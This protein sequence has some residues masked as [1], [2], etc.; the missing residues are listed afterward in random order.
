MSL[1]TE[2]EKRLQQLEHRKMMIPR[3]VDAN[4]NW[5]GK[6]H[7]SLDQLPEL[8]KMIDE[9]KAAIAGIDN[10]REINRQVKTEKPCKQHNYPGL[11]V[12]RLSFS[13]R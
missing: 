9:T 1:R 5:L 6:N 12:K 2:L 11:K 8:Q 13:G 3:Y 10:W 4:R 7:Y